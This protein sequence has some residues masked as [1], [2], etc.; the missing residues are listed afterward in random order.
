MK[1]D[2]FSNQQRLIERLPDASIY[3]VIID[4]DAFV[5][6]IRGYPLSW[7]FYIA[8]PNDERIL[9]T[10]PQ[11]M[12]LMSAITDD[13]SLLWGRGGFTCNSEE[14]VGKTR[15]GNG[16]ALIIHGGGIFTL[17]GRISKA[18]ADGLSDTGGG[19]LADEE[20]FNLLDGKIRYRGES[21]ELPIYSLTDIS[22]LK[23]L[24]RRFG[25]VLDYSQ[26]KNP[27]QDGFVQEI[28]EHPLYRAWSSNV[29]IGNTFLRHV[30]ERKRRLSKQKQV[31]PNDPCKIEIKL[32]P[33]T[34]ASCEPPQ[35]PYKLSMPTIFPSL[36]PDYPEGRFIRSTSLTPEDAYGFNFGA[37]VILLTKDSGKIYFDLKQEN[38][39]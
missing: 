36:N 39:L 25:V 31:D 17:E 4:K 12:K 8:N 27:I 9:P 33:I 5:F 10:I 29:E 19:K 16:V 22:A 32:G 3:E 7:L 1:G 34:L 11:A 28:A 20:F 13:E 2:P 24:P 23:K 14:Y 30:I 26:V 35:L 15:Q 21:H 37:S 6:D 18:M 38:K